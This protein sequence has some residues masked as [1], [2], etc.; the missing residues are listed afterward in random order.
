MTLSGTWYGTSVVAKHSVPKKSESL[1][2]EALFY[3]H[4]LAHLRGIIVPNSSVSI[5]RTVGPFLFSRTSV[6]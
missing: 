5:V 2:R 3:K 4:N 6:R 1:A